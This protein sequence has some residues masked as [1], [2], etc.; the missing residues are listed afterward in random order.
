MD[1]SNSTGES[2]DYRVTAKPGGMALAAEPQKRH[3]PL[4]REAS[5]WKLEGSSYHHDI[6]LP[7]GSSW[8][9]EFFKEGTRTLLATK[10]VRDPECLVVLVKA[11]SGAY[12]VHV[13]KRAVTAA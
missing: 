2:T 7:S 11:E 5:P 1:V 9:V 6:Q 12:K 10:T 3:S 13:C 4:G 8:L